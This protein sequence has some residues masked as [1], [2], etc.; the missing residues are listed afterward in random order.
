MTRAFWIFAICFAAT[1][2]VIAIVAT[3]IGDGWGWAIAMVILIAGGYVLSG[4]LVNKWMPRV[5]EADGADE[6]ERS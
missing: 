1:C 6:D 3:G 4:K 2:T 5:S